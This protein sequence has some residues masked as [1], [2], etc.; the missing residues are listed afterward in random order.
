MRSLQGKIIFV[1]LAIAALTAALALLALLELDQIS[2]KARAGSQ[3]A[4][5]FDATLEVRRFEKNHFLYGQAEDLR[6]NTRYVMHAEE[7]LRRNR[8]T[9]A[10]L[11]GITLAQTLAE[12][13][14]RYQRLMNDHANRPGNERL[15]NEVRTLGN[16]IVT[17]GERLAARERESLRDALASHQRNLLIYVAV[18]AGL[19]ALAG[20]LLARWVTRPLK[21]M[22]ASMEAVAQGQLTRLGLDVRERELAS[23]TQAFNHVL[24]EL[25]RRQHTLVRAEKLASLGTLLSGVAHELNNPLSNISGAAQI[26]KE[27]LLASST[28]AP[29]A[30][31]FAQQLAND[32]DQ[33]SGRAAR[34]VRSLLDYARDQDFQRR[35]VPLHELLDETLRFLKNQRAPG[36][37]V[38]LD[39]PLDLMVNADRPRL[40]QVFLNLFK[41]ALEAVGDYGEIRI[42]ARLGAAGQVGESAFPALSGHCKPGIAVVDIRI[43]DSGP[44]IPAEILPRIFDP[45][46]TTK[47]VG[48]G[49]GLGLFIVHE[50]I[51]EHGGCIGVENLPE[52]GTRFHIR[53]PVDPRSHQKEKP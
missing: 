46:F 4:E 20:F 29:G 9:I 27:E 34:I 2:D 28:G 32:I 24:D 3:V 14:T 40:Q 19:L 25:E 49:N 44:G 16:R 36:V 5:F 48:H 52:G 50:I 35:P 21:T 47:S 1:Y 37:E 7:L 43:S 8:D 17:A 12:D 30:D 31:V 53:L 41:N 6:E 22:E 51:E 10:R 15:A 23:L 18:V 38:H 13:L 26:L 11:G 33:E 39:I 42:D 45:F